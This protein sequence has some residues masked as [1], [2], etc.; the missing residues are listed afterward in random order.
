MHTSTAKTKIFDSIRQSLKA[1]EPFDVVHAEHQHETDYGLIEP[2]LAENLAESFCQ[3]LTAIGAKCQIVKDL[4]EAKGEIENLLITKN[5]KTIAISDSKLVVH[6]A[7]RINAD[8]V[9]NASAAELFDCEIGITSA[10]FGIS[11]TGTLVIE[12][13]KEFNR[14]T[15]LVPPTHICVL[16]ASKL[17]NNLGDVLRELG[18][19]LSKSITFITGQSRTSDIELTLA[20]GVHGP[21]EL[22][23]IIIENE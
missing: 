17:R 13:D 5:V 23:V 15:S 21:K 22:I 16:E 19:D 4:L 9:Q 1:S 2:Y 3:N 18:K 12:S 8:F 20:L 14:L 11:E 10:Q 6:L 7:E